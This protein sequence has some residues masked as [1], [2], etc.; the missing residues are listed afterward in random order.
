MG[1]E[2]TSSSSE[3]HPRLFWAWV[4]RAIELLSFIMMLALYA[5][6]IMDSSQNSLRLGW[7]FGWQ[8]LYL[9]FL[10]PPYVISYTGTYARPYPL[11]HYLADDTIRWQQVRHVVHFMCSFCALCLDVSFLVIRIVGF[12]KDCE[13]GS[14]CN[15]NT[16]LYVLS[17][18]MTLILGI[19]TSLV[20]FITLKSPMISSVTLLRPPPSCVGVISSAEVPLAWRNV[21]D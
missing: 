2:E 6:W 13:M 9:W 16:T 19:T 8:L 11:T 1:P 10:V 20:L 3:V 15:Q 17:A 14:D 4:Q 21:E 18:V 7:W 12:I 5:C